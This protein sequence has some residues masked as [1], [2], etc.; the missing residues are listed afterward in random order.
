LEPHA[1]FP[2][3]KNRETP[4][5]LL[6]N[7]AEMTLTRATYQF[8][9]FALDADTGALLRDGEPSLLGQ[10]GAALLRLL[11]ERAPSPVG[12]DALIEAA[13]PGLAVEDSNLT[14]QIAALRR[15]LEQG[16]GAR[17]IETLP[18]R[19]YRYAGPPVTRADAAGDETAH[20]AALALPEKPSIAVLPFD[21]SDE[22]AWLADGMVDDI[23]TGL[24][25]I[26]WL[27]VIARNS[28]FVWRG[29]AA[30]VRQAG[31]DL[32]VRYILQGSVR[33]ADDRIRINAQLV[34]AA[35]GLQIWA[36]RYD[37]TSGDLFA[38]Q[39]EIA[40]SVIGAIEPSLRRAE[41]ERI[42][43]KRP[44]SLDAYELVLRAQADVDSG[45]HE[46]SAAALPLLKRALE[47]DPTYALAHG[48]AAIAHHNLFLRTGL[49][50]ENR[51]AAVQHALKAMEHGRDDARALTCAGFS[52]GMDAHDRPA[53]FVAFEAALALSPSTALAWILGSVVAAWAGESERAIDWS[54]RGMRLSPFD[55]WTFAAYNAQALGHFQRDRFP[56]AAAAAYKSNLANPAHS[57]TWVQLAAS[58]AVLGRLE[59]ARAAATRVIEL[60][61]AFHIA[62]QLA[63]VACAPELAL[64]LGKALRATGLPE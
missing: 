28:S 12:K 41:A 18:R 3:T 9:S 44:D 45:M 62:G 49:R 43:R 14:V 13:W 2:Q 11:L 19:G 25:R 59:E 34:D 57:I 20:P 54:E 38:L 40:L 31:R 21:Q 30:N 32:G 23:I 7:V 22:S 58:L 24:S 46:R 55:P 50:E 15:A 35:S 16:G 52:L 56:E 33:R 1:A 6:Q 29:R 48:L 64:K 27:F 36:E 51:S 53:A 60:Q 63:G 10:R 4:P 37:R 5:K 17:W 26:R 42:R 47:L 39:D 61:P 8:G